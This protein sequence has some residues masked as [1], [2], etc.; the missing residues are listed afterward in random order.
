MYV[1]KDYGAKEPSKEF[2]NEGLGLRELNK[3][4]KICK[5]LTLRHGKAAALKLKGYRIIFF[6][7]RFCN[8]HTVY[9]QLYIGYIHH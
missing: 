3:R 9:T 4:L 6:V 1:F 8:I 5:K 2:L 7:F